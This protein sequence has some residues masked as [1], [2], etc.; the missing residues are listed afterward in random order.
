MTWKPKFY[1]NL[2]SYL[3]NLSQTNLTDENRSPLR[4]DFI[5]IAQLKFFFLSH[6]T[7]I[8]FSW[9]YST[10]ADKHQYFFSCC[11][12]LLTDAANVQ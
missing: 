2:M 5:I 7:F 8:L 4:T 3:G 9:V 6:F 10:A 1:V 11:Q 12:R